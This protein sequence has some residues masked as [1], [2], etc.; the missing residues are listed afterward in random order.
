M[1]RYI[2]WRL[3]QMIPLVI[4]ITFVA[5][6]IANLV[7]GSPLSDLALQRGI[8]PEDIARIRHQLGLDQPIY[9]RYFQWLSHIARGDLGLSLVTF[10]PVNKLI[11]EKLPNT[12][13]LTGTALLLSLA[14]SIPVGVFS[15]VR[16][17]SWFDQIATVGAVAGVAVPTFWLGLMLI[18]IFSVKFREWGL[19]SLPPGGMFDLRAGGGV[20]DRLIHLIMPAFTLA[21]VQTAG[22]TRYIRSQ[23]LEVLRQDYM[24]IAEAKGLP[25]R[26]VIFR[27]GFRNAVL[28]L[29]TLLGLDLPSLFSGAVVTE[30]IFSWN[31]LGRLIVDSTFK[32]DYTVI[33]DTVLFISIL[34]V[35]A[36]LIAD[37]L[38]AQL[39]PRIRLG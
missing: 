10:Q 20:G 7:P 28:P 14:F 2:V 15:A 22:W 19:P 37:V 33:M 1:G 17:N 4:G 38:Y 35:V 27:H 30:T 5:F 31:G 39:D 32:R 25:Q 3:L 29:I 9:I 8:R 18:V 24:R 13:L 26:L 23:M 21:F 6:A 34:T 12:L 36:N 16:R 11:L